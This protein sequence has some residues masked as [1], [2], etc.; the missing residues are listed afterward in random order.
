MRYVFII[1]LISSLLFGSLSL[2][3]SY[4]I[5][6]KIVKSLNIPMD[7]LHSEKFKRFFKKYKR[8]KNRNFFNEKNIET[9][10]IPELDKIIKAYNVPDIFLFMAMAESNFAAKARSSKKAVG[11]W[12]FMPKTAE[13]Y[14]LRIDRF[15][16][17]RR[18][19]IKSTNAAIKYLKYLHRMFGKWY[20]AALA[21]NAGEG[22]V[23]KAIKRAGTDDLSVLLDERKKYLPKESRIYLLKIISLAKMAYDREYRLNKELNYILARSENFKILP[24]Y[25]KGAETL[26]YISSKIKLGKKILSTLNP[27]YLKGFTPPTGGRYPIYLPNFKYADFKLYYKPSNRYKNFITHRVKKGDSLYKIAKRYDVDV[28]SLKKFNNLKNSLLKVGKILI[29]PIP[30]SHKKIYVVK[31][32]DTILKI[33]R[34]FGVDAKKLKKWNGKRDNFIRVGEKLVILY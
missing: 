31:S 18:D 7:F 12:Q 32:G 27:Q 11:I 2:K 16:D 25:V 5:E 19:P 24:V 29:V 26:G 13:K 8:Y 15:I 6:K 1:S 34:R 28:D 3:N 33:A 17:E 20:L 23:L 21:Y 30:K 9:Y 14:G 4:S 22:T 10:F